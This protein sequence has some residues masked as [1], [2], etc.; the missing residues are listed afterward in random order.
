MTRRTSTFVPESR[1]TGGLETW[2]METGR[3]PFAQN[4]ADKLQAPVSAP[5]GDWVGNN[6][7]QEWFLNP[8]SMAPDPAYGYR[9][10]NPPTPISNVAQNSPP[11]L[12][13]P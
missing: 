1:L 4:L 6:H 10:F 7:N 5:V 2:T 8:N 9:Q 13:L 12:V 11:N 3:G